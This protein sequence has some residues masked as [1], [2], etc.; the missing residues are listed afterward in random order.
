[1]QFFDELRHEPGVSITDKF[2][3]EAIMVK[4]LFHEEMCHLFCCND[5]ATGYEP[6]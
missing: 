2:A 3:G 6:H 1:M 4:D 5:F